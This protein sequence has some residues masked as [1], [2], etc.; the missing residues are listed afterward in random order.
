MPHP[1][2]DASAHSACTVRPPT[3]DDYH[4]MAALAGQLGYPCTDG[5]IRDRLAGMQN[6]D[7]YAVYIAELSGGHIA[8]WVGVCIF[9]AVSSD[10]CAEISGLI[11]DEQVRSRAIGKRLLDAAEEWARLRGCDVISVHSNVTRERA[12]QFYS[13]NGF[14]HLKTQKLFLKSL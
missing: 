7:Q 11:V 12:H 13:N 2:G 14:Q 9:R 1:H 5:T 8:G 3:P 6:S 4:K 10:K